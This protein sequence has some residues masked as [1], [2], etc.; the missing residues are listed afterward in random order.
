MRKEAK[1]AAFVRSRR[2]EAGVK[3]KAHFEEAIAKKLVEDSGPESNPDSESS[4]SSDD[5]DEESKEPM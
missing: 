5:S 3:K 1:L 2:Q 4:F